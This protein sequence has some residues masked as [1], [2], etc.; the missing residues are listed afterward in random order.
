MAAAL[1][2]FFDR[3]D[4]LRCDYVADGEQRSRRLAPPGSV[5]FEA[6]P[7]GHY[8]GSQEAHAAVIEHL[9]AHAQPHVWPRAGFVTVDSD[10]GV[11]LYAAFD[12]V[13][14]DVQSMYAAADEL[15]LLHHA[16]AAADAPDP[17]LARP[18]SH[19]DHAQQEAAHLRDVRVRDPRL[20]GWRALLEQGDTL[21]LPAASGVRG[22]ERWGHDLITM[23]V[24]TPGETRELEDLGRSWG[25]TLEQ[26]FLAL[27]IASIADLEDGPQTIR[28]LLSVPGRGPGQEGA[29]G[30]FS[31]VGPLVVDVNPALDLRTL[32]ARTAAAADVATEAARLPVPKVRSLLVRPIEPG[33]VLSIADHRAGPR[34]GW[35]SSQA[36]G[37]L[38]HVPASAQVH[39]WISCLSSGTLMEARHPDTPTCSAWMATVAVG[40]RRGVLA[41]LDPRPATSLFGDSDSDSDIDS[42]PPPSAVA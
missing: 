26:T 34:R 41:A 9:A 32:V 5:E 17:A 28:A 30:W 35:R 29:I 10:V 36:R 13:T 31:R 22:G 16:Y 20:S 18:G 33:L 12:H 3:H 11:T 15:P 24:A 1:A 19:L 39:A 4:S 37:F 23:P 27:L 14:F 21:A 7:V 8:T 42:A 2:S 38:G 6:L 40:V 25:H